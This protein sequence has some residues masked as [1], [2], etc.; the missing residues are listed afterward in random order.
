[1]WHAGQCNTTF[2]EVLLQELKFNLPP[3]CAKQHHNLLNCVTVTL[4]TH[5][6]GPRTRLCSLQGSL[7]DPW[8]IWI[9]LGRRINWIS[10]YV[11]FSN[12]FFCI[13]FASPSAFTPFTAFA[14]YGPGL[15][16]FAVKLFS[17][18]KKHLLWD[19]T[20][21]SRLKAIRHFW[22]ICRL[23]FQGQRIG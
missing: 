14:D 16:L 7:R 11:A 17:V 5:C 6:H 22:E 12:L 4:D 2:Q 8:H 9:Q 13:F 21:C 1:M 19:V 18:M 23:H 15:L 3:Q 20:P 10:C